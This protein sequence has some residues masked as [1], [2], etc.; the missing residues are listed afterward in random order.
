METSEEPTFPGFEDALQSCQPAF[1]ASQA[2]LPGSEEAAKMT[3][4]SGRQ[5]SMLLDVSSPLGAFSR[6]L[7]ESSLWTSSAQFCYVW[8]RLDTKF[9]LS[10]FQLTPLGLSTEGSGCSLW[11]TANGHDQLAQGHALRLRDQVKTPKLWPTPTVPNGGRRNPEGTSITGRKPDGGKAQID[12]REFAIR[13]LPTPTARDWKSSSHAKTADNSRPLSEVMGLLGSQEQCSGSLN[14]RFVEELMGFPIDHTALKPSATH[15]FHSKPTPSLRQSLMSK[16][17]GL[18]SSQ[19]G[20]LDERPA[21]N[22]SPYST[23]P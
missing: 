3:V 8:N 19:N 7:L 16:G 23:E 20:A 2:P 14:P 11:R 12:L 17:S 10:A 5:L 6:I 4:G 9:A 15:V 22:T 1:P 13:M 21:Q 18:Q